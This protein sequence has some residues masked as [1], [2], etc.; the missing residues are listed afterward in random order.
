MTKHAIKY[1]E[2]MKLINLRPIRYY[3]F[4]L[5]VSSGRVHNS[6]VVPSGR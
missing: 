1:V 4:F 2:N 6:L 3:F 5:P